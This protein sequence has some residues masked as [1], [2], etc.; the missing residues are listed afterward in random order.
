MVCY[1]DL[2]KDADPCLPEVEDTKNWAKNKGEA[3]YITKIPVFYS[4]T[5]ALT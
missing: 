3:S 4:D 5:L 1:F 2:W